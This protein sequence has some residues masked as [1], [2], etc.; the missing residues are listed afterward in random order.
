MAEPPTMRL[1][2]SFGGWRIGSLPAALERAGALQERAGLQSVELWME[3]HHDANGASLWP[4]EFDDHVVQAV[5]PLLAAFPWKGVHL[6]FAFTNFAALNPRLREASLAQ[7]ELALDVC[8]ALGVTYAVTHARY[9]T[10]GLRPAEEER[11]LFRD[12]FTRLGRRAQQRGVVLTIENGDV[13]HRLPDLVAVV[14]PLEELGV[15][16]TLDTGH[17]NLRDSAGSFGSPAGF[18]RA[19]GPLVQNVHC[20]DNRGEWD[21]HL[22]PGQGS[23]DFAALFQ[24]LQQ[25]HANPVLTMEFNAADDAYVETAGRLRR[26]WG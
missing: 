19:R 17:A 9:G 1:G 10:L 26:W 22:P 6:P 18:I 16:I 8:G 2:V 14:A 13:L 15:G 7:V 4:W 11:A 12:A 20:Q 25:T 23:V 24:A 3:R 21:E 5:T